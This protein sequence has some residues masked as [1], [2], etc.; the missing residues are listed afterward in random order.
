ME[1]HAT[2]V[3]VLEHPDKR[4]KLDIVNMMKRPNIDLK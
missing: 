3:V 1:P 2:V 4:S